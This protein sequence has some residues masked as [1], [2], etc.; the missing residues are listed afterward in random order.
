MNAEQTE[1]Y[2][3]LI[4]WGLYG[5]AVRYMADIILGPELASTIIRPAHEINEIRAAL[6]TVGMGG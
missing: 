1:F 6:F 2:K 4:A 3:K 5:A